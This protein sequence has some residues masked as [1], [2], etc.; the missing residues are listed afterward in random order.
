MRIRFVLLPLLFACGATPHA[1]RYPVAARGDVVERHGD[2]TVRDPYRWLEAMDSPETRAWLTEENRLTDTQSAPLPTRAAFRARLEQLVRLPSTSLPQHRGGHYFFVHNDGRRDQPTVEITDALDGPSRTLIDPNLV[3]EGGKKTFGGMTV[4]RA[5]TLVGWAMTEGGGDWHT[6]HLRDIATGQDL[7]ESFGGIKYYRPVIVPGGVFYSRFPTPAPG[8]ELTTPDRDCKVYFHRL[9]TPVAGDRVVYERRD[10]PT[11]QFELDTTD[12]DRFL[13]IS[14]G[15][16]EVGDSGKEQ[17]VLYEIGT[18]TVRTVHDRFDEEYAYLGSRNGTLYF[19]TTAGAKKKRIAAV[20]VDQ[21]TVWRPIIAEG[22]NAID[23]ATLAGGSLL[24]SE[25]RDAHSV[26]VQYDLA[27]HKLRELTL[28]TIGSAFMARALAGETEAFVGFSSFAYPT[29]PLRVDLQSGAVTPW[30]AIDPGFDPNAFE[31]VQEMVVSKDGTRVPMF[32]TMKRG[33]ARDSTHSTLLTGYGF[34]GV[35]YTPWFDGNMI[36]WME[37]G[38][39]YAVVNV[40]GGGEYGEA[41]HDAGKLEHLQNKFDDFNAAAAWLAEHGIA[42]HG[43][44]GAIGTSGGGFLVG[45]AMVQRPELYGAVFPIAGVLDIMR[46]HLFGE[47]AGWQADMGHPDVDR[48]R[49]WLYAI[50]PLHNVRPG[51]HYPPTLV[52]TADHDVRVAPLHSYKFAAA[53][54][55]AQAG[56]NPILLRVAVNSG[57]GG[58]R[59]LSQQI[60]QESEILAFAA[61]WL[62]LPAR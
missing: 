46:F 24:L 23:E 30:R 16:G 12:D 18:G 47:G 3:A 29:S 54:Q 20:T 60:D 10:Q 57:H 2:L 58:G 62:D 14:M 5:G 61:R 7:P 6:W 49:A 25:L 17:V 27:G 4:D 55:A 48:E 36:A 32:I 1:V 41:W 34:G 38:G 15:D 13:V 37:R 35:S 40:R 22:A 28:P 26:V 19:R 8:T 51:T 59:Q 44:V 39:A 50:S 53:L 33:S 45:A 42:A 56:P 11:W 43:R 31:T 52:I 21:P 9:G